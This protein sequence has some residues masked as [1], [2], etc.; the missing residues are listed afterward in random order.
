[1]RECAR[2]STTAGSLVTVLFLFVM[3]G[4]SGGSSSQSSALRGTATFPE[5]VGGGPVANARFVV[6]DLAQPGAPIIAQG[7]SDAFGNWVVP[8]AGGLLV[9]VVFQASDNSQRVRVSGLSRPSETGS[10]K[11]LTG[12]TDI[13]CEAGLSAV[14]EGIVTP[15]Q[16]NKNLILQLETF[17]E[18]FMNTI[19]Y[20]DP[21]AVT[22]AALA[23]RRLV[24]GR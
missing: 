18:R 10:E 2:R 4:C 16:V 8:E 13:A 20:R 14:L 5:L 1:M 21:A 6:L 15:N 9:A 23:V 7:R 19:N 12:Q 3:M 17:S 24:L 22:A 11:P